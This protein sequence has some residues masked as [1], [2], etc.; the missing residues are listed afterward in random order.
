MSFVI[1]ERQ[2]PVRETVKD[3]CEILGLD[4]LYVANEGKLLA[5]VASDS[6]AAVLQRM[7]EHPLGRDTQ[8]IGEVVGD[9][10]GMVLMKT[11]I[12]GTRVV[13]VL[14]GEQLPRICWRINHGHPTKMAGL[15]NDAGRR[16]LS[17]PA[18]LY[19]SAAQEAKVGDKIAFACAN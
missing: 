13:D 6:A 2:V 15:W 7:R 19:L 11:G 14:F 16:A 17:P 9:H 4:P 12:G 1:D 10:P 3:A 18:S 8:V 5:I